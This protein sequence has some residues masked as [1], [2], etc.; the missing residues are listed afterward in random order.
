VHQE[1]RAGVSCPGRNLELEL[2]G[3]AGRNLQAVWTEPL[4]SPFFQLGTSSSW[5]NGAHV[6]H[7]RDLRC[8]EEGEI[9]LCVLIQSPFKP[10]GKICI[11]YNTV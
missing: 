3:G 1:V 11:D 9:S 10:K 7:R 5:C 2:W 8:W 6:F 4:P